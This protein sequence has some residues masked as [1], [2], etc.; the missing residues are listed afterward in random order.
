MWLARPVRAD[1]FAARR[2]PKCSECSAHRRR[3]FIFRKTRAHADN[4]VSAHYVRVAADPQ[5]P[6]GARLESLDRTECGAPVRMTS[7]RGGK[8]KPRRLSRH[9]VTHPRQA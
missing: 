2:L 4:S 8:R 9:V 6:D 5:S 7:E 3:D 1:N